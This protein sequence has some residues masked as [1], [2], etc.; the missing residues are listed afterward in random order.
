MKSIQ[1]RNQTYRNIATR[2]PAKRKRIYEIIISNTSG[3]TA[4]QISDRYNIP[5]NQITGRITELKDMCFIKEAH[6]SF[7][8]VT[9][10]YCTSYKAVTD[11]E[12]FIEITNK[13]YVQLVDKRSSL[14]TDHFNNNSNHTNDF[15][16]KEL[17]KIE[18]KIKQLGE[19]QKLAS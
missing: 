3:I 19:T 1:T 8:N 18:R 7:N 13:K 5:I 10:N 12:E 16:K 17:L 11:N 4:Q 2:I 9:S 14:I 15:I 6:M